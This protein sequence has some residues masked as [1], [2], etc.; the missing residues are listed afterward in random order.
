MIEKRIWL[1]SLILVAVLAQGSLCDEADPNLM[2]WWKLDGDAADSSGNKHDGVLYGGTEW[3]SGFHDGALACD[4]QPGTRV[5][6]PSATPAAGFAFTGAITWALWMK[7]PGNPT[8]ITTLM[9]VGP[10]GAA[11]VAGNKGLALEADGSVRLRAHSVG[12]ALNYKSNTIAN[13]NEWHHV[14]VTLQF[15]TNGENDTIK[16]YLN[17]SLTEGYTAT[18]V[19]YNAMGNPADRIVIL[20][21]T[22]GWAPLDGMLDDVRI[23]NR[24]LSAEEVTKLAYRPCAYGP[25]P[26]DGAVGVVMPLFQWK[27]G[28]GN[29]F[30][31][32]YLGTSPE[33]GQQE[34]VA[35]RQI[36]ATYY[37]APG[38]LPGTTYYWRVDEVESDNVTVHTGTVWSFMTQAL[39]AYHPDP[40]DGANTVSPTPTLT[41]LPGV[42]AVQHRLYFSDSIEKVSQGMAD[43][44]KG[45]LTATTFAPGTIESLTT[46][47]WRVDEILTGG[48]VKTG[49][50]WSFTTFLSVDDFEGYTD[51]L[52]AKT[53]IFDTWIDGLADGLS[54]SVVGNSTAPFAEQKII[55]GGLQSMPLDFNNVKTPF[56]SETEREFAPTMDWTASNA[57]TLVLF[58]RGTPGNKA[59]PLYIAVED[60]AKKS[61][62]VTYPDSAV[63]AASKWTEWKIPLSSFAGV[64]LAKVK[65]LFIG[66]GD[67]KAPAAGG[68]GRVYIDDV[69]VTVPVK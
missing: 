21:H 5:E 50:V 67:K 62:A 31:N 65:V 2:G 1:G 61:A 12:T 17:G 13:D 19:N 39:T 22:T 20:G 53:T 14:A 40:M 56:F 42:D 24:A 34:L 64:N 29:L 52:A 33:L 44:D 3:V 66:V 11:H 10:P 54:N 6:M 27:P 26:R 49:P 25:N 63:V 36:L 57:D 18:D 69:F 45:T 55:H 37:H 46:Y 59:T 68:A 23:Y 51:D 48:A 32:I 8:G 41:W 47:H 4:G 43:A 30:H 60:S 15:E 35:P 38:L 16:V 9:L 58:V 7:S 28:T